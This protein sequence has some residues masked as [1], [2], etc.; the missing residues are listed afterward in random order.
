MAP[1]LA[2]LAILM[3]A[4]SYA[5]LAL[6]VCAANIWADRHF[7]AQDLVFNP[8]RMDLLG[9]VLP[10]YGAV[11][12][13]DA[14]ARGFRDSSLYRLATLQ[15]PS[16][17]SDLAYF[18]FAA[19]G[20]ARI[21]SIPLLFGAGLWLERHGSSRL[22][23]NFAS[24]WP[25]WLA[26]PAVG[27]SSSFCNYWVH[28]LM[29]SRALWP[30]HKS[31][32]S[33]QE[34]NVLSAERAHPIETA[35]TDVLSILI[36]IVAGFP[37]EAVAIVGIVETVLGGIQHSE[38]FGLQSLDR[39]GVVTSASHRV[40][41]GIEAR[42]HDRNFGDIVTWWDKLFGT[43]VKPPPDVARLPIGVEATP[44]RHNTLH[45]ATEIVMQTKDWLWSLP[46]TLSR[47]RTSPQR[48]Q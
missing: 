17:F 6:A 46:A 13:A 24:A 2:A 36:P 44:G 40:H 39:F 12:V 28:R 16:A 26:V 23:L 31:H 1:R 20:L 3:I 32:H 34:L 10:L 5:S 18:I 27:L 19:S 9:L 38:W 7:A 48:L 29:H 21:V 47:T 15:S 33:A 41:H 14:L 8:L 30:L 35:L 45:L 22:G 25:L 37:A 42:Y 11:L 43:Y 4:A